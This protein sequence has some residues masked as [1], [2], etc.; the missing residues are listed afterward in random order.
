MSKRRGIVLVLSAPSGAGK[1]TVV[2]GLMASVED[3]RFSISFTTRS[4]RPNELDGVDYYFVSE[5]V[6]RAKIERGEFLEWAHVY[7]CLYGTGRVETEAVCASGLDI[8]LDVDVQGASQIRQSMPDAVSVFM[9][10]PSFE[11]LERRIRNR[12]F[13]PDPSD[14]ADRLRT[15]RTDA[16]QYKE[17]D[18]VIINEVVERSVELLRSI[19]L[20]ER[21]RSHLLEEQ[22]KPILEAFE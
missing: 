11:E 19:L 1:T 18:Y 4:P 21:A 17:Y 8:L 12:G 10:P 2:R 6:F 9:L 7:G 5:D 3:A 16:A 22:V 20:A 14:V 13:N 15:A